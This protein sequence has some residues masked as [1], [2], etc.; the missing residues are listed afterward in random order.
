MRRMKKALALVLA[1]S[2]VLT[3]VPASAAVKPK[4]IS[5]KTMTAGKKGRAMTAK[6]VKKY[7]KAGYTLKFTSSKKA[8]AK[9]NSK[10][11]VIKA[12][13]AGKTNITC[14]FVKTGT[15]TVTKKMKLTVKAKA[16]SGDDAVNTTLSA[17]QTGEK[18]IMVKGTGLTEETLKL[19]K[20]D[21]EVTFTATIAANGES[22][23]LTTGGKLA[24][25][26]YTVANGEESVSIAC[27]TGV[28][29]SIDVS[30]EIRATEK[31][32]EYNKQ[33]SGQFVYVVRNQWGED[34]TKSVS[35]S[36]NV[37]GATASVKKN[38]NGEGFVAEAL[39][40]IYPQTMKFG[41]ATITVNIFDNT[42]PAINTTK[43]LVVTDRATAKTITFTEI[44]HIEG[45]AFVERADAS[46]FVYLFELENTNGEIVVDADDDI[47][48]AL[49]IYA[50]PGVTGMKGSYDA[51][52]V[53]AIEKAD[54]TKALGIRLAM[55][56]AGETLKAGEGSI[57]V[58]DGTSGVSGTGAFVV[59][60]GSTVN[61]FRA[62]PPEVVVYGEDTE[63][64][65]E[66]LDVA[67]NDVTDFAALR[68]VV[69]DTNFQFV[70]ED[71][72]PKLYLKASAGLE[73][74]YHS[75]FFRTSTYATSTVSFNVMQPARPA[76]I[77]GITD[78]ATGV[79]GTG[80]M[81][82]KIDN[83]KFLDQY[84][85]EMTTKQFNELRAYSVAMVFEEED[86]IV[87]STNEPGRDPI[88]LSGV[89]VKLQPTK[90]NSSNVITFELRNK[91][92]V[93]L[94]DIT[95]DTM[96]DKIVKN[97]T[98][99]SQYDQRI[100]S[101]T[102]DR[103]AR[104]EV[105]DLRPMYIDADF[106]GNEVF[107]PEV[108]VYGVLGNGAK[109][110]LTAND[111]SVTV[112]GNG[113]VDPLDGNGKSGIEAVVSSEVSEND[114][115]RITSDG[116]LDMEEDFIV[117]GEYVTSLTRNICVTINET[118]DE[119]QKEIVISKDPR[120]MANFNLLDPETGVA[121]KSRTMTFSEFLEDGDS[122]GSGSLNSSTFGTWVASYTDNYSIPDDEASLSIAPKY[123]ISDIES[124]STLVE[125]KVYQNGTSKPRVENFV[126]GTTFTL[127][128]DY[129]RGVEKSVGIT[130]Q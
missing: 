70:K 41:E 56:D 64:E 127:T 9:I 38:P 37:N 3:A 130:I 18:E 94:Q 106:D 86:F 54:G 75:E 103:I 110:D 67:G 32:L 98:E 58:M 22:A 31:V 55:Q 118:G 1:T 39:D 120:R 69:K 33:Y 52:E 104:Y 109:I 85:R 46:E 28:P 43:A 13:K 95:T 53:E 123:Y 117:N 71:G 115:T 119:I 10:T 26:T 23:V 78:A 27:E 87:T 47:V 51:S 35:P 112:P 93:K 96:Y 44:Y 122:T 116:T 40:V 42:Y 16:T 79:I 128:W 107:S 73:V 57:T 114:T 45:D 20:A 92:G 60:Y 108:N 63:F 48:K 90:E 5:K 99:Y 125:P 89:S 76:E 6:K 68:D 15:K 77:V 100:V 83:F 11:G 82:F 121:I 65:Y 36:I 30:D 113:D 49:M 111:Y 97:R 81:E 84:G 29:T 8:V 25:A 88:V 2:M 17:T 101:A 91:E 62:F 34:V 72:V 19:T 12:K 50:N 74:G 14:K 80:T 124:G 126:S 59:G 61:T 105:S 102:T 66:A 24:E 4:L 129:G 21:K 7:K